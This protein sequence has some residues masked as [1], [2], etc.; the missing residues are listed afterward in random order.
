MRVNNTGTLLILVLLIFSCATPDKERP[1]HTDAP[2]S[3]RFISPADTIISEKFSIKSAVT[4]LPLP[5][6][7]TFGEQT[8][9][10][11]L[12]SWGVPLKTKPIIHNDQIISFLSTKIP[13]YHIQLT[14]ADP[15]KSDINVPLGVSTMLELLVA[16]SAVCVSQK[17]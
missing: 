15:F 11:H 14:K 2:E 13:T 4:G 12:P 16:F 17:K 8:I 3:Q 1:E 6:D 7:N 10:S 5:V 9:L